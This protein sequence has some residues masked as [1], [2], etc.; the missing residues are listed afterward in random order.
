[1]QIELSSEE[2]LCL[3][4][5]VHGQYISIKSYFAVKT[6]EEDREGFIKPEELKKLYNNI[7]EQAQAEGEYKFLNQ[8]K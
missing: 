6:E 8:I 1:M 2:L 5:S 3:L 7:L 4:D